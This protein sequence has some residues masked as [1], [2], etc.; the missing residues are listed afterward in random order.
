MRAVSPG[1][2]DFSLVFH[3]S[4]SDSYELSK[5]LLAT[6]DFDGKLQLLT[7]GWERLLGYQRQ[8]L[9]GKT[10]VDLLWSD[11]RQAATTV[12]AILDH[13]DM[14]PLDLRVRC[15][16]GS[17]KC[18]R[19]HRRYDRLEHMMYIVAEETANAPLAA[20]RERIERR[21]AVRLPQSLM[22]S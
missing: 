16:N 9:E 20:V 22:P 11:R 15:R 4:L 10:L 7:S 14:R 8:E 17:G 1:P 5:V 21:A 3:D 13:L 12:T 6:A 19:L 2:T 18:L